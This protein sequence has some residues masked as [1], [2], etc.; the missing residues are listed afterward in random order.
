MDTSVRVAEVPASRG[1]RWM[2]EA[3]RLF[4]QKPLTWIALCAGWLAITFSLIIVPLVGG[5]IANFLQPVFFASF[6]I[7]AYKQSAGEAISMNELFSGFRRNFRAL[8][9]LGALLLLAEIAIFALMAWMGMPIAGEGEQSFTVQEYVEAL[10]G[11]EWILAAGF[12]LTVIVKGALWFAPPLIAFHQMS[13]THAMRWSLYAALSN[14]GAMIVYG[15]CLL[16][17]FFLGA[18]PWLLGML[19]VVPMMV[20]STYIGYRDVFEQN[21]GTHP[22]GGV[23]PLNGL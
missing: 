17:L 12:L 19:V 9:N 15:A 6:A 23:R 20:I 21:P 7:A 4:R 1:M 8:V 5:V 22:D 10:R 2:G 18:I 3:F 11:K 13:T 14:M 16:G